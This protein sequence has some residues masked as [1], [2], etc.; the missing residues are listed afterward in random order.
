VT[1]L[2]HGDPPRPPSWTRDPTGPYEPTAELKKR[3]ADNIRERENR[4]RNKAELERWK[5]TAP[6]DIARIVRQL[7]AALEGAP[8]LADTD[9]MKD[10]RPRYRKWLEGKDRQ[11]ALRR[12]RADS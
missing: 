5:N 4:Q 10:F 9:P 12:A 2:R 11:D 7:V 1:R 6:R 3:M 8:V